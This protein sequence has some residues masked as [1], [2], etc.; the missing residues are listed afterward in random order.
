MSVIMDKP[1]PTEPEPVA[2][3]VCLAEIPGSVAHNAEGPD[4]VHHYCGLECL[5]QWRAIAEE[6]AEAAV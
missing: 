4:Y 5:A 3:A 1:H 2:C 6:V